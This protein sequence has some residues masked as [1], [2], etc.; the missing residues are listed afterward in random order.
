MVLLFKSIAPLSHFLAD[1]VVRKINDN[2][3][4]VHSLAATSIRHGK[5]VQDSE[6][7]DRTVAHCRGHQMP[8]N[9]HVLK[10]W[11]EMLHS[12]CILGD[13]Q[14]KKDNIIIGFLTPTFWGGGGASG[15]KCYIT[16]AFS[17]V[18]N[19]KDNIK[20]QKKINKINFFLFP[21]PILLLLL[22][23]LSILSIDTW[24]EKPLLD[25]LAVPANLPWG[26]FGGDGP[27]LRCQFPEW[28]E[29]GESA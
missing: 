20:A 27:A 22:K 6:G 7:D 28:G 15:Q 21:E 24:G 19:K 18:H 3:V 2:I 16:P 29:G 13:P 23:K 8:S 4:V 17:G 12:P 10:R 26:A 11:A 1:E 25:P 14:T 5:G 9:W